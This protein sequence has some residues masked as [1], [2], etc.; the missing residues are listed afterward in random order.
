MSDSIVYVTAPIAID[1]LKKYFTNKNIFYIVDYANSQLKNEKLLTYLSNL[2]LPVDLDL[3]KCNKEEID[4][5]V[6]SYL[7]FGMLVNIK[8][9]EQI[10]ID[11]LGE[12]KG[13]LTD[14]K[15]KNII[16]ENKELIDSWVSK[17]DSLTLYNMYMVNSD[18][19]KD[20]VKSHPLDDRDEIR[21]INFVSLIKN[22]E[23]CF[24]Y[25]KIEK[26]GLKFYS[27]YFEDYMFKG[28]NLYS[29]WANENNPMFL[30]TYGISIGLVNSEEY[31]KA[32]K[33]SLEGLVT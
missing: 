24:L 8:I 21:G 9:L 11:L 33:E 15:Y 6:L 10:T 18:E 30:L 12:A 4:S 2:D 27:K 1:D 20:F 16:E 13:I 23:F 31:V 3:S 19:M 32:K 17:V 26:S 28:K 5:L 14:D 22:K 7:N 29:Y 25:Q